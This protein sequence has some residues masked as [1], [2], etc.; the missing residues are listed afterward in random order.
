MA[1]NEAIGYLNGGTSGGVGSTEMTVLD[2]DRNE[3]A[4]A[5]WFVERIGLSRRTSSC[6]LSIDPNLGGELRRLLIATPVVVAATR[7]ARRG[8]TMI[9]PFALLVSE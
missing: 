1:H 2:H 7:Q 9:L 6:V 5:R 4:V 8:T 3:V